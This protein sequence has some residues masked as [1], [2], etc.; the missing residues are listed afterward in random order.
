MSPELKVQQKAKEHRCYRCGKAFKSMMRLE[1]HMAAE[2]TPGTS[3]DIRTTSDI[4]HRTQANS[5][6]APAHRAQGGIVKGVT[7][8]KGLSELRTA[9][10]HHIAC[11]PPQKGTTY[12]DL[13]LLSMEKQRLGMELS[14]LEKRQK[15]IQE[16]LGEIQKNMGKLAAEAQQ[17]GIV[18]S[19]AAK[20]APDQ[21]AASIQKPNGQQWKMVPVEY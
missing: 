21:Q 14:L 7:S 17:G 15:H 16:R 1:H 11:K 4:R 12:L 20:P 5:D 6:S 9:T 2:H 8:A 10:T 19:S 13:Y 3:R 18:P